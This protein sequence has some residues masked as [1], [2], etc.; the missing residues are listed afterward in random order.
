MMHQPETL[1]L[2]YSQF[3]QKDLV[4][5]ISS[6]PFHLLVQLCDQLILK[7]KEESEFHRRM[8]GILRRGHVRH[9]ANL[10]RFDP[11]PL[12]NC[13]RFP[14]YSRGR[15]YFTSS[16]NHVPGL[17]RNALNWSH[18][19]LLYIAGKKCPFLLWRRPQNKRPPH[20]SPNPWHYFRSCAA[21]DRIKMCDVKF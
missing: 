6:A 2:K 14:T 19:I 13:E 4:L 17:Y 5:F 21:T 10:S 15:S 16:I 7:L 18:V 8:P 9:P 11:T 3:F 20:Q 1:F 12:L